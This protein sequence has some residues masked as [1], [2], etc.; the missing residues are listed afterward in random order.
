M[1]SLAQ[2]AYR[3]LRGEETGKGIPSYNTGQSGC[4][5]RALLET[6]GSPGPASNLRQAPPLI[7]HG[8]RLMAGVPGRGGL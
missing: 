5:L 8:T 3:L 6:L 1:W 7:Q 4:R 2:Q